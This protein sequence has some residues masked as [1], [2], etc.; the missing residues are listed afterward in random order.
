MSINDQ[1]MFEPKAVVPKF[2]FL[3]NVFSRHPT[4][5][6]SKTHEKRFLGCQTTFGPLEMHSKRRY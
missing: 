2:C 4:T 1:V 6:S 3:T 5:V